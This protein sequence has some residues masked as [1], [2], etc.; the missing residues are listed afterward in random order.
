M[1]Q[2]GGKGFK[3]SKGTEAGGAFLAIRETHLDM[4]MRENLWMSMCEGVG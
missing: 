2:E 4:P 1:H 3:F